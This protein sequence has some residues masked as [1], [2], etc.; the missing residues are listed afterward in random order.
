MRLA[1][2]TELVLGQLGPQ[3]KALSKKKKSLRVCLS[4]RVLAEHLWIPRFDL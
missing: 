1:W 4:G 3:G 2:L